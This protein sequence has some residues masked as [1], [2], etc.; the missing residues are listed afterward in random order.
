MDRDKALS[1]CERLWTEEGDIA[2]VL[3]AVKLCAENGWPLPAWC[4]KPAM[5]GLH[6]LAEQ[7]G[8]GRSQSIKK[9]T[10]MADLHNRRHN[11]VR[12]YVHEGCTL[13]EAFQRVAEREGM[14]TAHAVRKSYRLHRQRHSLK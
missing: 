6:M 13:E 12:F 1:A 4:K 3:A 5:E 8:R 14:V 7:S 9:K 2:G 11:L 10:E